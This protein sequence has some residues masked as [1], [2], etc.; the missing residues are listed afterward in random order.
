MA[1][2]IADW[3]VMNDALFRPLR[4]CRQVVRKSGGSWVY[5]L[6]I[7]ESPCGQWLLV[8]P[9]EDANNVVVAMDSCVVAVVWGWGGGPWLAVA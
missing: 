1:W 2:I 5:A 3:R 4:K 8:V 9:V 6:S 7:N